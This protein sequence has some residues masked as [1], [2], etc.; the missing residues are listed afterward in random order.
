MPKYKFIKELGKGACGIVI[1]VVDEESNNQRY[2]IKR[3]LKKTIISNRY[4][5]EAFW[6]EIDIMK[7]NNYNVVMELCDEDL[8]KY[9]KNKK[10]LLSIEEVRNILLQLN[11]VFKLMASQ[12]IMHRDLKPQNIMIK[13]LNKEKTE[14][15]VKL[16]DYGFSKSL[17]GKNFT[18]SYLGTPLTMAP[19]V[20]QRKEYSMKAD[21]WS[22]GIIIYLLLFK[23]VPY[24]GN[25]E[26][27]MK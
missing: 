10:N 2:A 26:F 24:S 17:E 5:H 27:E 1:E 21:L 14:Y 22:V 4:L 23:D 25:N 18:T 6:K 12:R 13:F 3:I 7:P 8:F 20:L 19:E 11:N 15:L 9:I 16:A